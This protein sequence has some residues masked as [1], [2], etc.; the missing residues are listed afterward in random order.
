MRGHA[1][2]PDGWLFAGRLDTLECYQVLD[3][4]IV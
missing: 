2:V 4:V 1:R 3:L